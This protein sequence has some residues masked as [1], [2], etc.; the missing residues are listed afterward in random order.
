MLA[1]EAK[2][3]QLQKN[4]Q[5]KAKQVQVQPTKPMGKG[6]CEGKSTKKDQKPVKPDWLAKHTP[7]KP[8]AIK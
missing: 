6:P 7:P 5:R 8:D 1:L 2:V 4:V 3:E